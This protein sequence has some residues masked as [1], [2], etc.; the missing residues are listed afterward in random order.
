MRAR[1][2]IPRKK[3]EGSWFRGKAS[4]GNDRIETD[5]D[6]G[7]SFG[8]LMHRVKS[9]ESVDGFAQAFGL[10]CFRL[11]SLIF[12]GTMNALDFFSNGLSLVIGWLQASVSTITNPVCGEVLHSFHGMV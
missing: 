8:F 6:T 1:A 5:P 7:K 12:I 4:I 10:E 11:H 3:F 9:G 2:H